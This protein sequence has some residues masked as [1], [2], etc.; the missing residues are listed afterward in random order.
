MMEENPAEAVRNNVLGT[1]IVGEAA[2]LYGADKFVLISTDK[3]V[4]PTC[5]MGATKRLAEIVIQGLNERNA[6][7]FVAVRFGNVLGSRGSVVPIFREQ[8]QRGGP[9]TITHPE[10]RRYFMT[11]SE[12]ALLVLQAGAIGV[13]GEIFVL[14]MGAPIAVLDLARE[15][16]LLAGLEPDRDIP[17]VFT[18]PSPGEKLF[19]DILTAEEGTKAT[20]HHRIYIAKTNGTSNKD[21]KILW[22]ALE[23]LQVMADQ[24]NKRAILETLCELLPNFYPDDITYHRE[25]G[26]QKTVASSQM[27]PGSR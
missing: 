24:D 19:E 9:V 4:N 3:A 11:P 2:C 23:K 1:E 27:R 12:A 6:C 16:I 15:M 14:D 13:G 10:M 20:I 8:I 25:T 5:V 22:N 17:I 7:R 21:R 26:A 18:Q